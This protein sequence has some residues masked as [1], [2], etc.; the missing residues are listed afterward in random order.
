MLHTQTV[1]NAGKRF[2]LKSQRHWIIA[3]MATATLFAS[4]G[5]L[6][7]GQAMAAERTDYKVETISRS[8]EIGD[9]DLARPKDR[10]RIKRRIKIAARETCETGGL[11]G[12]ANARHQKRCV[13]DAIRLAMKQMSSEVQLVSLNR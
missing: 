3:S 12:I 1:S 10:V 4:V 11:A 8:I 2:S 7:P 13:S 9:L 5:T 6:F